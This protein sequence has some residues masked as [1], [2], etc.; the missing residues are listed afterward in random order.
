[1]I[2]LT[3][4]APARPLHLTPPRKSPLA[5]FRCW[6]TCPLSRE[7]CSREG[8]GACSPAWHGLPTQQLW[9]LQRP[10]DLL[11]SPT[12]SPAHWCGAPKESLRGGRGRRGGSRA[13]QGGPGAIS[14]LMLWAQDPASPGKTASQQELPSL[15]YGSFFFPFSSTSARALSLSLS[16]PSSPS[17]PCPP[18]PE[19]SLCSAGP[20][21]GLAASGPSGGVFPHCPA[22]VGQPST[23]CLVACVHVC[24]RVPGKAANSC[25]RGLWRSPSLLPF[26]LPSS[27]LRPPS[28]PCPSSIQLKGSLTLFSCAETVRGALLPGPHCALLFP[29][30]LPQ[31]P[32]PEGVHALQR[33]QAQDQ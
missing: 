5:P 10:K 17:P 3:S 22:G 2:E 30:A 20:G 31:H 12:Q 21:C 6:Q 13:Q 14:A 28:V 9:D 33:P 32:G 26:L 1:M 4:G 27:V 8:K 25:A 29:A 15:K 19:C 11:C 7:S 23:V 24:V 16:L 18:H